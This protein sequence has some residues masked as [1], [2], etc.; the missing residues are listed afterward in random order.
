MFLPVR[1]RKYQTVI[2]RENISVETIKLTSLDAPTAEANCVPGAKDAAASS[3]RQANTATNTPF[4]A[5][6]T[7]PRVRLTERITGSSNSLQ[8][9]FAAI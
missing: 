6:K 9:A 1:G 7:P 2:S 5:P 4:K 8:T 3:S